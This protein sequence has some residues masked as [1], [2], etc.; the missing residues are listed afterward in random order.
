MCNLIYFRSESKFEK[1]VYFKNILL[2]LDSSIKQQIKVLCDQ[3]NTNNQQIK[4]TFDGLL[5]QEVAEGCCS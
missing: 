4:F 2:K 5:V 3:Y 1:A